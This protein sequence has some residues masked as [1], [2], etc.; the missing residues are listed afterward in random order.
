MTRLLK[1]TLMGTIASV[2]LGACSLAWGSIVVQGTRV[3]YKGGRP[4]VTVMLTNKN[5]T[6]VLIQNWMDNGDGAAD[7][8]KINVPFVI[9]PPINRVDPGKGQTLRISYTGVP[10][11]STS[12]ESVFWL[13]IL[14]IPSSKKKADPSQDAS[15]LNIAFRTRVKVFYRPD[16]LAGTPDQ[17]AYNLKWSISNNNAKV[18]NPS[19]YYVSLSLV[20]YKSNGKTYE[21]TGRMIAP[22][23]SDEYKFKNAELT[24]PN[25]LNYSV[26]DDYGALREHKVKF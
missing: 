26:I 21:Q 10:M 8:T 11:L 2:T 7:P 9:T 14:E 20:T 3:I 15:K 22:G 13:N 23:G 6:P 1:Y 19:N 5:K 18:T 12:R 17:A 16:G 4:E 24:N 25:Q